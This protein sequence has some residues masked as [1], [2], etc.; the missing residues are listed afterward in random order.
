MSTAVRPAAAV[1]PR[2][3]SVHAAPR[4][5]TRVEPPPLLVVPPRYRRRR[6]GVAAAT[7]VLTLFAV[8]LGLVAFQTRLAQ[9]QLRLDQ[10]DRDAREQQVRY[11][12]LR[13]QVAVLESP[14]NIV[15]AARAQGMVTP[16]QIRYVAVPPDAVAAVA[17]S[18]GA[19]GG[20]QVSNAG[21]DES[22]AAQWST[23]KPIVGGIP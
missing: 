13:G 12:R 22:A 3:G 19:D 18:S 23:V 6:A 4:P 9:G 17:A 7:V 11:D 15:A 21:A 20:V 5:R 1:A 10:L 8:M 14:T 2:T 16:D